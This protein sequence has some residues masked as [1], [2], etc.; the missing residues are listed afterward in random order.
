M[1]LLLRSKALA[2]GRTPIDTALAARIARDRDLGKAGQP[3]VQPV[4]QPDGDPLERR[5]RE[6]LDVVEK[7]MV[8]RVAG[9]RQRRFEVVERHHD[10]RLRVGLAVDGDAHAEGMSVYSR[11]R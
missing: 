4:P 10:A 3:V 7:A 5:L 11:I 6:A 8:E 1:A 9:V 2:P